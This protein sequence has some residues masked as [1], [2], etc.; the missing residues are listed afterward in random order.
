M[1]ISFSSEILAITIENDASTFYHLQN[2]IEKNFSKRIGRK[3][4]TIVFKQDQEEVQRRYFLKLVDKIY[5]RKNRFFCDKT[6][7][8]IKNAIDKT[9][10]IVHL[11]S[12]QIQQKLKITM[13]IEDNY[14]INLNI[15]SK[16]SMLVSYLKNYFKNHLVKYRLKNHTVTI[17]TH[18]SNTA[19]LLEKLLNQKELVGCYVD[20]NYNIDDFLT[21][22]NRLT[23][24]A[25]RRKKFNTLFSLL[26]EFYEVL[27][28][29]MSDS[30]E[31]IRKS[32]LSLVKQYHPDTVSHT[33]PSLISYYNKKFQSIQH[34][35]EMIKVHFEHEKNTQ[36]LSA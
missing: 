14:A 2:V 5:R 28:C 11:K 12:N 24:R 18:S 33:N 17:F 32:Y 6:S 35:Y 30:F 23:K 29:K 9:I 21:Y 27:D 15:G 1:Q 31:T 16:N 36:Y 10:K 3:N 20:F 4:K 19:K 13:Q 25:D 34:A 7:A 8:N 22:K 26:E